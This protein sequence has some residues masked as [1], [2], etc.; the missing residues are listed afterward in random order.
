M[1]LTQ[2][3]ATSIMLWFV[4]IDNG[5]LYFANH[6]TMC[7]CPR[8]ELGIP[9]DHP[10]ARLHNVSVEIQETSGRPLEAAGRRL[11]GCRHMGLQA[12]AEIWATPGRPLVGCRH[13]PAGLQA[14]RACSQVLSI[15]YCRHA[16]AG[17]KHA[18]PAAEC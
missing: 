3:P 9:Y 13:A 14:L 11:L 5:T 1:C 4:S 18:V 12:S 17:C 16:P 6:L 2:C 10:F 15:L 7:V 8:Q